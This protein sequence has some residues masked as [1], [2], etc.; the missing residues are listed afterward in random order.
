MDGNWLINFADTVL[1]ATAVGATLILLTS[2]FFARRIS[3]AFIAI[4][5][6][7]VVAYF[8]WYAM[9]FGADL[10]AE[11]TFV[12]LNCLTYGCVWIVVAEAPN[13]SGNLFLDSQKG[14]CEH[15]KRVS[16]E[17]DA[18]LRTTEVRRRFGFPTPMRNDASA[19]KRGIEYDWLQVTR[20][21]VAAHVLP[22]VR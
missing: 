7:V 15:P 1:L 21:L 12:A 8:F 11:L 22:N 6:G 20:S 4:G 13:S 5:F 18:R 10:R 2:C 19:R 14:D 17:V 3:N 9:P 16:I